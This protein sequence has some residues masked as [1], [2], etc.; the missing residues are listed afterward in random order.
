MV[1]VI[2]FF[3]NHSKA[4]IRV[5]GKLLEEIEVNNGL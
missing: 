3:H 2:R 1:D 5:N 4:R